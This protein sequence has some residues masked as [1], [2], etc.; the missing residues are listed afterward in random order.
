VARFLASLPG[1]A[2]ACSDDEVYVNLFAAGTAGIELT[3]GRRLEI[4]QRGNYPWSGAVELGIS[5]ISAPF[6]LSLKLR[7]PGW[8]REQAVPSDLY[9]FSEPTDEVVTLELNGRRLPVEVTDGYVTLRRVW[10]AGDELRLHLPMP[11]RRVGSHPRVQDNRGRV[12][13]Q[14][15]PIVYAL[16]GHDHV[17]GQVLDLRLSDVAALEARF[18]ADLLG[19]VVTLSGRAVG[20]N[21]AGTTEPE[22]TAIP[23]FAWANRGPAQM[24]V[25][26]PRAV[27]G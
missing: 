13:L 21:D 16:E 22:L 12:A 23:Y 14:R 24:L 4:I 5:E 18:R 20:S 7:I 19:G 27:A 26:I 11:V 9:A 1:Y 8:A 2:Y 10:Q 25:W 6:E 17:G 15:G 3:D